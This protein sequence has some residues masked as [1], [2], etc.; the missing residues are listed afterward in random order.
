[1][2]KY[3][4]EYLSPRGAFIKKEVFEADNDNAAERVFKRLEI[5]YN[6]KAKL[7]SFEPLKTGKFGWDYPASRMLISERVGV[8]EYC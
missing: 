2:P 1:M 3:H 5:P 6:G 8:E 4:V 7:F